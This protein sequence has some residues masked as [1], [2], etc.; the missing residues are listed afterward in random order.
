MHRDDTT[1]A[2]ASLGIGIF[3][4]HYDH[5]GPPSSMWCVAQGSVMQHTHDCTHFRFRSR[6]LTHRSYCLSNFL[7]DLQ[8]YVYLVWKHLALCPWFLKQLQNNF[9]VIKV[10]GR[11][12]FSL[13]ALSNM[14][15]LLLM[16]WFRGKALD[17]YRMR[18]VA[19]GTGHCAQR[20]GTSKPHS[21]ASWQRGE[22]GC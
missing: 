12:L 14:P 22:A 5:M 2:T 17:K 16:R 18:L 20:A 1:T 3:Q 15:D 21:S 13:Q 11:L 9:R 6:F 8:Q 4:L 19:R 10:E 7:N